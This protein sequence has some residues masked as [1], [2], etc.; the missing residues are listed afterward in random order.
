MTG[1]PVMQDAE[2]Q[3]V[4]GLMERFAAA[5]FGLEVDARTRE[6]RVSGAGGERSF[7]SL[8]DAE[9]FLDRQERAA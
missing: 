1:M 9:G 3:T 6:W 2:R 8:A 5:G 4:P 7:H